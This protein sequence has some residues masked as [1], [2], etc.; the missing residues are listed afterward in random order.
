MNYYEC[1]LVTEQEAD[2]PEEAVS[3][4]ISAAHELNWIV[5]WQDEDGNAQEETIYR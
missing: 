1:E 2:S 3:R 4:A 5:R